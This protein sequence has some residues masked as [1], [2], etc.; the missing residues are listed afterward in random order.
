A[1]CTITD[2]YGQQSTVSVSVTVYCV[3]PSLQRI[4]T[5]GSGTETVPEGYSNVIIEE[6]GGGSGGEGGFTD[7]GVRPPA[8]Y[9]GQGGT[10]GSYCRSS[11]ACSGGQTLA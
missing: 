8:V 2:G 6:A 10:S 5:S 3:A 9:G 1:R 7:G 11:Y 4:Y